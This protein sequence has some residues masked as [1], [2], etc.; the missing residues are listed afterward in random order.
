MKKHILGWGLW[1]LLACC[2]YFFENNAGTRIVLASTLL[3]PLFPAIRRQAPS[4]KAGSRKKREQKTLRVQAFSNQ[5]EEEPG[6]VR[7]YLPGDPINRIHWK[8]SA[9]RDELLIREPARENAAAE[10]SEKTPETHEAVTDPKGKNRQAGLMA[11]ILL[12]ALLLLFLIPE[13]NRGAQALLNRLFEASERVNAYA[14]DRFPVDAGQSVVLAAFLFSVAAAALLLI[15]VLSGGG[16]PA[17]GLM[18]GCAAF[19][20]YFG[21][22]F[23]A[24]VHILLSASFAL[25]MLARPWDRKKAATI[26]AVIAAV[27]LTVMIFLPGVNG[28]IESASE[29]VRDWLSRTARQV[30]GTA[31]ETAEGENETRHM[32]TRSLT[33]GD[34]EAQIEKEYRLATV[35]EEQISLPH[36][37][38]YLR[39]AF[40]LLLTIALVILPFLPFLVLNARRKRAMENRNAFRSEQISEAVCAIF[41]HVIA[42]LEATE[43]GAGNLPYTQWAGH[44]RQA[45][46]ENYTQ[47]FSKCAAIF[48]EAAYSDHPLTEEHRRQ[49][50]KLLEA[51][52]ERLLSEA[53]WKQ[54]LRL[55]YGKCLY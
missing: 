6:D 53:D 39:I 30:T 46:P 31:R 27:S 8:L 14:Y 45:L 49:V 48:E 10:S 54:K 32:H 13:A 51:T 41:Q 28:T 17:F 16:A 5:E 33:S 40:L 1:L 35:E 42:W 37:V 15:T 44:L 50:L 55:K 21:L 11:A 20:V 43:H 52:E 12:L 22:T 25:W 38:S 36:W 2:L 26:L 19:Q 34:Q 3:L 24:W 29:N 4:P 18:A 23:P 7:G 9:K 47:Q